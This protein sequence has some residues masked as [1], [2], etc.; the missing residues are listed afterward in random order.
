MKNSLVFLVYV[1][2]FIL[3]LVA[4]LLAVLSAITFYQGDWLNGLQLMFWFCLTT[5]IAFFG[6]NQLN[7]GNKE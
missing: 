7:G 4:G 5:G 6:F 2:V 1:S 3:F